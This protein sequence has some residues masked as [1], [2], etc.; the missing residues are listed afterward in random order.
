[1]GRLS[2]AAEV[3]SVV[4]DHEHRRPLQAAVG[5]ELVEQPADGVVHRRHLRQVGAAAEPLDELRRRLVGLVRVEEVD[6]QERAGARIAVLAPPI[7][8]GVGHLRRRPVAHLQPP[9]LVRGLRLVVVLE[10]LVQAVAGVQ[11]RRSHHR[12]GPHPGGCGAL[13]HGLGG[14]GQRPQAVVAQAVPRR[15]EP[16]QHRGVR[17]QGHRRHR[18][19]LLVEDALRRQ[20]VQ[21]R[22]RVVGVAVAAQRHRAGGVEGDQEDRRPLRLG[23]AGAEQEQQAGEAPEHAAPLRECCRSAPGRSPGTGR[24]S[25]R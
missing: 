24:G 17:R 18:A 25:W 14:A 3:L 13:G 15:V 7:D 22:R 5:A 16:G 20:R 12:P 8:G 10:A 1:M 11:H 19:R 6:P 4:A 21:R 2:V 9:G 23:G